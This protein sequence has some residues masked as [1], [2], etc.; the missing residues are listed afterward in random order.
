[1]RNDFARRGVRNRHHLVVADR[2]QPVIRDVDRQPGWLFTAREWPNRQD[3]ELLGI[4]HRKAAL[5]LEVHEHMPCPVGRCELRFGVQRD[6][7]Q[8]G[9]GFGID[10][11]RVAA[12]AVE[13][14]NTVRSGLV[15]NGIGIGT[16]DL[17][18]RDPRQ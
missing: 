12:S 14:E 8:D 3:R 16:R 4:D 10:G 5:V 9:M 11:R 13:R 7:A 1:M 2:K 15:K 18:L 17:D 6:G